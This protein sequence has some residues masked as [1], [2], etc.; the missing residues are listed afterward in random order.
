MKTILKVDEFRHNKN[1]SFIND[2]YM[3]RALNLVQFF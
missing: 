1:I 2:I 3:Q